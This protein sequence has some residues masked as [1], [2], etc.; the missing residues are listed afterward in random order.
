[1]RTFG[2]FSRF[3]DRPTWVPTRMMHDDEADQDYHQWFSKPCFVSF[4]FISGLRAAL[5]VSFETLSSS[6]SVTRRRV[7]LL[8]G[9][10]EARVADRRACAR[11]PCHGLSCGSLAGLAWPGTLC[12]STVFRLVAHNVD[13]F[14]VDCL[15]PCAACRAGV[16]ESESFMEEGRAV[17]YEERPL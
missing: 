8:F 12:R 11:C 15:V 5:A 6:G 3:R 2:I 4:R 14:Q 13:E 10:W 17:W 7:R 9:Q 16:T 1:M